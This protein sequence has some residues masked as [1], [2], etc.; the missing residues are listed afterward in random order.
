MK[1]S[2][3]SDE[4][5]VRI[6]R[7]ADQMHSEFGGIL[8]WIIDGAAAYAREGLAP[9]RVVQE[10]TNAYF[11]SEDIFQQWLAE[12]CELEVNAFDNPTKLFESFKAYT[13]GRNEFTGT[14]REFSQRLEKA[15][16]T[17]GSSTSKGGRFW[18]GLRIEER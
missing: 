18:Q 6:L 13:E 14:N 15:G 9:P 16:Y 11:E 5:I 1:K 8:R 17:R 4:Q 12:C 2:R 10:A 3:Y 7:E